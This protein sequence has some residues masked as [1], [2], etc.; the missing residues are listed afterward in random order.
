MGNTGD[1][2]A[3]NWADGYAGAMTNLRHLGTR[4]DVGRIEEMNRILNQNGLEAFLNE[5]TGMINY[6]PLENPKVDPEGAIVTSPQSS[7]AVPEEDLPAD[8]DG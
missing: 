7:E 5:E 3:G 2:A 8:P 4:D 1:N 6:R